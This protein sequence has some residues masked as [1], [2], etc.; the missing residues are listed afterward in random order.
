VLHLSGVSFVRTS[1]EANPGFGDDLNK[2]ILPFASVCNTYG[3]YFRLNE[4]SR[5]QIY[6]LYQDMKKL[7]LLILFVGLNT[8]FAQ[9]NF[10]ITGADGT[11]LYVQEFGSGNP[12]VILSGGPGLNAVY[13][14]SVY[15]YLS[16]HYRCIVPDQRGTG[17]SIIS[18]VDSQTLSMMNYINDLEAL[19]KYLKLEQLTLVGHSWGGML[20]MEYASRHP[21]QT[22]KLV[23]LGPGGPTDK[24]F[25]YFGDNIDMRLHEEDQREA[26]QLDSLKKPDLKAIFPGYF[27][28]RER[29]LASKGMVTDEIHGQKGVNSLAIKNYVST[30]TDR[31]NLLKNYKGEVHIIQGRQDPVD[32]STI[33]EIKEIL[34]QSQI[35]I[36]EKSG[37]FPWLEKKE[38]ALKFFEV[39]DKCLQ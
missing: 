22:Q 20:A 33:Y 35:Y 39:L 11:K 36:L 28:S 12:L 34:P 5:M 1:L 31:V 4:N 14:D 26:A 23:L 37:H 29:A 8:A 13:M 30:K 15:R 24:F 2:I 16:S 7:F 3:Y 25:T 32:E 6:K 21:L 38:Q 18:P 9:K 17:K 19:R 27:F 10:Y